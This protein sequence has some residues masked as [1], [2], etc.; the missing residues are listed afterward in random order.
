MVKLDKQTLNEEELKSNL[1][2]VFN[3]LTKALSDARKEY[4]DFIEKR[5][6][7]RKKIKD[8]DRN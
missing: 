1:K 4:E 3:L 5:K 7:I 2:K 6:E 8:F